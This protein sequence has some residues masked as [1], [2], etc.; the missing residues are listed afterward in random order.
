MKEKEKSLRKKSYIRT[1]IRKANLCTS[2]KGLED[3][4]PTT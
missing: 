3:I 2:R 4:F 1:T